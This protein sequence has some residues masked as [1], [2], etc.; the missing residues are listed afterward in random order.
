MKTGNKTNR[1]HTKRA[2]ARGVALVFTLLILTLMMALSL[3]MVIALSSQT[4]IGGYYRNFRGAFYAADSGINIARQAM[5]NKVSSLVPDTIA[6][7]TQ[8]L[9]TSTSSTV[10]SYVTGL[11]SN[12]SALNSGQAAGSWPGQFKLSSATFTFAN[13]N[14]SYSIT[15]VLAGGPFTCAVPPP[16]LC[17]ALAG[18]INNCATINNFQYTY[19]YTVDALGQVKTSEQS[20]VSDMGS[21]ILTVNISP[22]SGTSTATSFAAWGMFI[23]Q[24]TECSGGYLVPGT[25]SGPVFT[26]GGWTFG[27][28]GA[29]IFTDA[30][31]QH[32][33]NAGFQFSNGTSPCKTVSGSSA[34]NSGSP[35]Q[36]IAPTFQNGFNRSQPS[37][38]LPTNSFNQKRAVLDGYGTGSTNPSNAELHVALQNP[39]GSYPSSG[40]SSGVFLPYQVVAGV[41][42]MQGGGIYVEGNATSVQLAATTGPGP[43][44]NRQQKFTIVQSG[45]TTVVT[46]DLTAQT[47][48][49]K[50]GS[51]TAVTIA[52]LPMNKTASPPTPDTMLYVN[53]NIGTSSSTGLSGP[54]QGIAAVQDTAGITITANGN[55]NITGD[56]LYKTEPVT[57]TQNQIPGTPAD[58]LIPGN[59]NGQVLG[60]FTANG[61]IN[62]YNQQSNKN[63]QIDASLA[64]IASGG[65][66]ALINPGTAITTLNIVG[67]RIQNTIQNI[68]STTRN[69]F[70]D[71]RFAQGGFAPPWFPSTT[72]TTVPTGVENSTLNAPAVSRVQWL[73]KSCN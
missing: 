40:A 37:V 18:V 1:N 64:T 33:A 39:N 73:C 42:T 60:I 67:G 10:Q 45:T 41:N 13:C 63:L 50:I 36:T 24:Q 2:G 8:P 49:I 16:T 31:G 4:F 71:R 30:V 3:G 53:G 28:S 26:N 17:S 23:D 66:G 7:G 70:F 5:I 58:T 27:S 34:T 61:N 56:I 59:N 55:I 35:S 51:G 22:P 11:Y 43:G 25:I 72:V 69:V 68:N 44:N 47:T 57:M 32:D 19:N 65:S 62:L 54:G 38:P 46:L 29:Y 15:G 9:P 6:V 52:G 14:I 20:E 21:I 48:T 12:W